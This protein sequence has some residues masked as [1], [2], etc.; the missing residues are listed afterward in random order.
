MKRPFGCRLAIHCSSERFTQTERP[1]EHGCVRSDAPLHQTRLKCSRRWMNPQNSCVNS[2]SYSVATRY[3]FSFTQCYAAR[4]CCRRL[5]PTCC[6]PCRALTMTTAN[7]GDHACRPRWSGNPHQVRMLTS[8][9]NPRNVIL[10]CTRCIPSPGQK[11]V[12]AH[13]E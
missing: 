6:G 10:L 7:M 11:A 9:P 12:H 3:T 4:L 8:T 13:F 2:M 5:P 1:G